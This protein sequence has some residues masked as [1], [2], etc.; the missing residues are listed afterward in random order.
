[1]ADDGAWMT[2]CDGGY[3]CSGG[4]A[5]QVPWYIPPMLQ[6]EIATKS[7][8]G[9]L[10]LRRDVLRS[11]AAESGP[12]S[13]RRARGGYVHKRNSSNVERGT[14]EMIA[15]Q[16]LCDLARLDTKCGDSGGF[17]GGLVQL[18][19]RSASNHGPR[20]YRQAA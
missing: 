12:L 10:G 14:C 7:I 18:E 9:Y 6:V 5:S 17:T 15:L 1:M 3:T 13:S 16:Q 2:G 11:S 20:S 4:M 19:T 8:D